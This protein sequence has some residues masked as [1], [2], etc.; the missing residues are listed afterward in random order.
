L[1]EFNE[2]IVAGSRS[3]Y[4]QVQHHSMQ[5]AQGLHRVSG[6]MII[7]PAAFKVDLRLGE[8]GKLI[9]GENLHFES[10]AFLLTPPSEPTAE[11]RVS[12]N[13]FVRGD[14]QI[15]SG[16]AAGIV[17][18]NTF[19]QNKPGNM[20]GLNGTGAVTW[21]RNTYYRSFRALRGGPYLT[22]D[23]WREQT[24]FDANSRL[25]ENAPSG[26]HVVV[27]PNKF[28]PGRAHVGVFSWDRRDAVELDLSAVVEPGDRFEVYRLEDL[29]G[30]PVRAD[31]FLGT[32]VRLPLQQG[33]EF[34][35]FLVR[36]VSAH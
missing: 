10:T 26:A 3:G 27:R 9:Y 23:Q 6:N 15:G 8:S 33:Q 29:R 11:F 7:G 35:I 22:W 24:R 13:F 30:S 36:A 19:R 31:I 20:I 28:E 32:P 12:D 16:P 25:V 4:W 5:P 1:K 14:L 21:D 18:G 17:T 34:Q 2:N